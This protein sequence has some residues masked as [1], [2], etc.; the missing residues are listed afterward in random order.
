VSILTNRDLELLAG[1]QTD[2][3]RQYFEELAR[4]LE[5]GD[6]DVRAKQAGAEQSDL[7]AKASSYRMG[8]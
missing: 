1:L 8:G 2:W 7:H 6:P 4:L 5:K 3:Q